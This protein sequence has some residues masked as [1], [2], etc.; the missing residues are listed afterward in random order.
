VLTCFRAQPRRSSDSAM[1]FWMGPGFTMDI[2]VLVPR[3]LA[4]LATSDLGCVV[5]LQSGWPVGGVVCPP[6]LGVVGLATSPQAAAREHA[7][8]CV[9]RTLRAWCGYRL[10]GRQATHQL[11]WY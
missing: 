6:G 8:S 1:K 9:P 4:S 11:R 3:L 10:P 5:F 7:Y 2:V